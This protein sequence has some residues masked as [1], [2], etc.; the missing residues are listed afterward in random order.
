MQGERGP[1][2]DAGCCC[3]IGMPELA[4]QIL[5]LAPEYSRI[6]VRIQIYSCN[7]VIDFGWW[8]VQFIVIPDGCLVH[9]K[10]VRPEFFLK[11]LSAW[12][13]T[14][15]EPLCKNQQICFASRE[16]YQSSPHMDRVALRFVLM[17]PSSLQKKTI[18]SKE[19]PTALIRAWPL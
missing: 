12:K 1:A 19:S 11:S 15:V 8:V 16:A 14:I 17:W 10:A 9:I 13:G 6:L 7:F 2:S 18:L 5:R 4:R 3:A